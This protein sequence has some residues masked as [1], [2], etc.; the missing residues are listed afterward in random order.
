MS[1][2]EKRGFDRSDLVGG[3]ARVIA[4]AMVS[5]IVVG[6]ILE[7]ADAE[8]LEKID[9]ELDPAWLAVRRAWS[10]PGD[11][12]DMAHALSRILSNGP[13]DHLTVWNVTRTIEELI[14][15]Q[16]PPVDVLLPLVDFEAVNGTRRGSWLFD[17]FV[18]T[19]LREWSIE[20]LDLEWEYVHKGTPG[21]GNPNEMALRRID[22]TDLAN[23]IAHRAVERRKGQREDSRGIDPG[24]FIL[25]AV[26]HL[27]A[28]RYE[29]AAAI[30]EGVHKLR[31]SDSTVLNNLGF[32]LLP[33]DTK[34]AIGVLEESTRLAP[35]PQ[36]VTYANL[37]FAHLLNGDSS[38]ALDAIAR[39]LSL[40]PEQS[41]WLW[42]I[43]PQGQLQLC[44]R[45][46]TGHYAQALSDQFLSTGVADSSQR[47]PDAD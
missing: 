10:T 3:A 22:T 2:L 47:A 37:A 18:K 16:P 45:M 4:H 8:D 1:E 13:H 41:A 6:V 11:E 36:A 9:F 38:K 25:I 30:Y 19:Y 31:P 43:D 46:H 17:R 23:E 34:R 39:C 32:C 20:T 12:R 14:E 28:K 24:D 29:A 42:E 40:P 33:L 35:K 27:Q 21:C 26:D 15:W 5:M 7:H 44:E